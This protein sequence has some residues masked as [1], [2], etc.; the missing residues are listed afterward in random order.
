MSRVPQTYPATIKRLNRAGGHLRA[1]VEMIEQQRPAVDIAQQ[2]QA[3]EGAIASARRS[4][5]DDHIVS[6]LSHAQDGDGARHAVEEF[7]AV[8]R[9]R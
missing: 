9:Y 4:L 1:I 7:R 3:V 5:I 8:S 6:C 2:L